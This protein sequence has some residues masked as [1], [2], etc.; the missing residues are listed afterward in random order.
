MTRTKKLLIGFLSLLPLIFM[1]AYLIIFF[2]FMFTMLRQQHNE[3]FFPPQFIFEHF[4]PILATALLMGCSKLALLIY[5]IIHAVDNKLIN[6]TERIVWILVFIFAGIIG[7]P[8][9]WYMRIWKE[10]PAI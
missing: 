4:A 1:M 9:Y 3:N 7:F 5:F 8:V 6:G 10:L 2:S